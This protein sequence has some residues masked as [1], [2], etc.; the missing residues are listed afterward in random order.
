MTSLADTALFFRLAMR[1][2]LLTK[3]D[4]AR[5]A[6]SVIAGAPTAEFPL[7]EL[8][9]AEAVELAALD[10]LLGSLPGEREP[11]LPGR[12]VL[13]LVNRRV[14]L[15][16]ITPRR[17]AVVAKAIGAV[18]ELSEDEYFEADW[19]DDDYQLVVSGVYGDLESH[20]LHARA[21]LATCAPYASGLPSTL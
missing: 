4:V 3:S 13:A 8:A 18:Q 7:T 1:V 17:A 19:L 6:Q 11:H 2:G 5:W 14:E 16:A 21:L 20:D 10:E 12:L 15:G 9:S